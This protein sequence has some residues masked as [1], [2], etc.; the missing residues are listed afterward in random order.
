M[1][2]TQIKKSRASYYKTIGAAALGLALVGGGMS[3][4]AA[5]GDNNATQI[6]ENREAIHQALEDGDYETWKSLIDERHAA[7]DE[8]QEEMT[9]EETFNILQEAH[10]LREAGDHEGARELLEEAG[11]D[12]PGKGMHGKKGKRGGKGLMS[13]GIVM[14]AENREAVK[15]A[16]EN[17][18]YDAWKTALEEAA[19]DL[20]EQATQDRFN[21]LVD[22]HEALQN[23]DHDT[24]KELGETLRPDVDSTDSENTEATQA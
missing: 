8:K 11:I 23:G 13:G 5:D 16:V 15:T 4:Y 1:E 18:D 12:K 3:A 22:I 20:L 14:D 24:A 10:E 6:Q 9:S 21:T 19:N 17:N 2:Q 7:M